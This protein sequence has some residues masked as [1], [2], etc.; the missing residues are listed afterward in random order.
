MERVRDGEK[1]YV[2]Q[3]AVQRQSQHPRRPHRPDPPAARVQ[4]GGEREQGLHG[5]PPPDLPRHPGPSHKP[6]LR[7]E[8][9]GPGPA[10]SVLPILL[11]QLQD[12]LAQVTIRHDNNATE[13]FSWKCIHILKKGKR[14]L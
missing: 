5:A 7:G 10:E 13:G 6:L 4:A 8:G 3:A 12:C 14:K 2:K 9:E 1:T 11:L